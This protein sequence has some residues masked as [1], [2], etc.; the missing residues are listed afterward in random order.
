M[1]QCTVIL[2]VWLCAAAT[3]RSQQAVPRQYIPPTGTVSLTGSIPFF[4]AIRALSDISARLDKKIIIDEKDRPDPI[5]IEIKDM[6]WREALDLLMQF[7]KLSYEEQPA[8]IRIRDEGSQA[9]LQAASG[10]ET[11]AD[12]AYDIKARE[13][14]ISAI[15]FEGDRHELEERGI[16]WN[17]LIKKGGIFYGAKQPVAGSMTIEATRPSEETSTAQGGGGAEARDETITGLINALESESVGEVLASPTIQVLEGEQG[18]VQVGQDFS[19]KQ[20]DFAGNVTDNF[21]STGIILTVKPEVMREDSLDFIYLNVQAE[22]S[23]VVPGQVSTIINKTQANSSLLLL[24]GERA[25]IAGLYTTSET[26]GRGGIPVLKD[27]PGWVGGIR[28]LTGYKTAE[29][30][31]KELIIIIQAELIP[32]LKKRKVTPT[33]DTEYIDAQRKKIWERFQEKREETEEE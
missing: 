22:R 9:A 14:N 24:D 27:L 23:S 30:T 10:A 11:S 20:V 19:L 29:M 18:R 1:K 7:H 31:E 6:P 17:A 13:V 3:L 33:R 32:E 5:H 12:K 25:V 21:V 16:N 4:Q 26:N 28:Y 15:F 2:L 8:F